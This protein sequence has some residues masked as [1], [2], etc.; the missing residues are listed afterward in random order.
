MGAS[1]DA[2][3]GFSDGG[4]L[5]GLGADIGKKVSSDFANMITEDTNTSPD[6]VNYVGGP[7]SMFDF[8]STTVMLPMGFRWKNSA[9]SYKGFSIKDAAPI[10]DTMRNP[11]STSP[12]DSKAEVIT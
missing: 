9:H 10:H 3:I 4:I 2:A 12:E 5:N 8:N 7:S 1:A 6:R 11:L